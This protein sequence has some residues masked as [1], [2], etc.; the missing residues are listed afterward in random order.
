DCGQQMRLP[1]AV[2]PVQRRG[3]QHPRSQLG[4]PLPHYATR[5]TVIRG[6]VE[7]LVEERWRKSRALE[8]GLPLSPPV[9][10]V[11]MTRTLHAALLAPEVNPVPGHL[12][13]HGATA[14]RVVVVP[15]AAG[16]AVVMAHDFGMQLP[17]QAAPSGG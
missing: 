7:R 10:P 3:R 14:N 12:A 13:G 15:D 6:A 5:L 8:T 17:A 16:V 1:A 2:Q 4:Q 11:D 9:E